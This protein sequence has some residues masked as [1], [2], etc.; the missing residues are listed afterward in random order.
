VTS[1]GTVTTLV[2]FNGSN[3]ALPAG[4]LTL[5]RDGSFYGATVYGGAFE[6][7][8]FRM[9]PQG[10]L[11]T[12][13]N[14]TARLSGVRPYGGVTF[15]ADGRLFGTTI[16]GGSGDSGTIFRLDLPPTIEELVPCAGPATGG[17][18][19]N[20]GQYLAAFTAAADSFL[21][22]GLITAEERDAVVGEAVRSDC[23]KR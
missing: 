19:K 18:W 21:E 11:T 3:G 17:S 12:L 7:T 14:F 15:G 13:A 20:H 23:G 6:G 5:G 9:T 8:V 4:G 22:A 1:D 10:R 16:T 2:D